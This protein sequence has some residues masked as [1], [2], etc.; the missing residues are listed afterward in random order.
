MFATTVRIRLY[1]VRLNSQGYDSTGTYWGIG[2]P[3]YC[4]EL[5]DTHNHFAT[6]QYFR[7]VSREDAKEQAACMFA[8]AAFYN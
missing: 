1:R 5:P 4:L 2:K 3:L 6:H 7:A 8:N